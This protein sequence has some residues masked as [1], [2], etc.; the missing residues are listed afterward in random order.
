MFTSLLEA[1]KA[2]CDEVVSRSLMNARI[3]FLCL[4]LLTSAG[5]DELFCSG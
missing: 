4:R 5:D 3:T 1:E 2:R